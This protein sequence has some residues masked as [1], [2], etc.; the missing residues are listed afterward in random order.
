MARNRNTESKG[1]GQTVP[2]GSRT[3]RRSG[4]HAGGIRHP[5]THP[6]THPPWGAPAARATI[7]Q[8]QSARQQGSQGRAKPVK[9]GVE[10]RPKHLAAHY[11]RLS[12]RSVQPRRR[13]RHKPGQPSRQD[14]GCRHVGWQL[15]VTCQA[16][17]THAA[18]AVHVTTAHLPAPA[19]THSLSAQLTMATGYCA[20]MPRQTRTPPQAAILGRSI[21]RRQASV[22]AGFAGAGQRQWP[23][24][25]PHGNPSCPLLTH[26]VPYALHSVLL[27][28]LAGQVRLV[29][30]LQHGKQAASK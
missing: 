8:K 6:P 26:E 21:G 2:A 28:R 13:S 9:A 27:Y 24:A 30:C 10:H 11:D 4:E 15:T 23:P 18:A 25:L 1:A 19:C 20:A 16:A 22:A 5:P 29:T 7:R 12:V 3:G 14:V 17:A